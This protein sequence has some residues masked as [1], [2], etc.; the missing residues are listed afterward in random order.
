MERGNHGVNAGTATPHTARLINDRVAFDLLLGRGPLTRTELRALTGLSR[1]TVA[2]LVDRL[3]AAGLVAA[4]GEA[5]ADRR[6]PNA[7]LYGVVPA[8]A[9]VAG[10]E[11]RP[12]VVLADIAD[13]TG[14]TAGSGRV[15][16]DA[17]APPDRLVHDAIA[18]ACADAGLGT[19]RL[20][21][22]VI[23]TPG[24]V[25]PA[26]GDIS[27]VASLPRWHAN[28]RD[29]LRARLGV[30]VLLDNEVNLVGLA[31]HRLGAARG[32]DDFA[33]LSVGEGLG[34]AVVLNGRLHRGA[35]G[36]AGEVSYLPVT[37]AVPTGPL[38]A[39]APGT[40]A[41]R[42]AGSFQA[43]AGGPAVLA[44][45]MS[46]GL[47]AGARPGS[48]PAEPTGLVDA[49]GPA[50]PGDVAGMVRAAVAGGHGGFLDE[51]AARVAVGAAGVCAVLDPGFLVLGGEVGMAGGVALAERVATGIAALTPLPTEVRTATVAGDPVVRG[52][53]LTA[54][55]LVYRDLFSSSAGGL[56]Q[57]S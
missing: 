26:S 8:R 52:A 3:E 33:L 35:S 9:H 28:L 44:L 53:V 39:G 55:D 10:V 7:R 42:L 27:F 40:L 48:T 38:V 34:V 49:G 2:E 5:G 45:A 23:G 31:E 25:D 37:A 30:E 19:D 14:R 54:L 6:G 12:G 17:E 46:H 24:L 11:V 47:T 22:V 20:H 29:V 51:L 13:L 15:P 56:T 16:L 50:G 4:V 18:A 43:L 1:P 41:G 21:A 36:G 57:G 32:R